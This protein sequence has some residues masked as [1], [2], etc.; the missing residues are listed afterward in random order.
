MKNYGD[1]VPVKE[2]K[3]RIHFWRSA[4]LPEILFMNG[5]CRD[6]NFSRHGHETYSFGVIESGALGFRYRGENVVAAAGM[7]NMSVP[8]EIHDGHPALDQGWEYRMAYVEPEAVR[9]I[10]EELWGKDL[11]LPFIAQGVL[12]S[13]DLARLFGKLHKDLQEGGTDRLAASTLWT[14]FVSGL[15]ER[16]G[17]YP[18]ADRTPR[19]SIQA[20][21]LF[22]RDNMTENVSLD[23]LAALSSLS[24]WHFLRTFR[25]ET[26]L[27]P[28]AYL[29]QLRIRRAEGLLRAG[30]SPARV[31]AEVGF[32]DQSHL[33]R[34]FRRIVGA[35]PAAFLRD[36]SRSL[37]AS[38]TRSD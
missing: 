30:F 15:L 23:E 38:S 35:T 11:G 26:G 19:A 34:W 37:P 27:P 20:A 36:L 25:E 7:I 17:E 5:K 2:G 18:V 12:E 8:G 13:R 22:L 1:A 31:A 3:N 28:H 33:T 16:Y 24:P 29:T 9:R 6:M 10:A 32:A 4:F 21:C 14:L